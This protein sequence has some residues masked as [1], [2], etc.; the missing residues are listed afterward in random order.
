MERL[1]YIILFIFITGVLSVNILFED[2]YKQTSKEDI[3]ISEYKKKQENNKILTFDEELDSLE[4]DFE[5]IERHYKFVLNHR[6]SEEIFLIKEFYEDKLRTA[7]GYSKD[8]VNYG[9]GL[10]YVHVSS[11]E[12]ALNSFAQVKD[13]DLPHLN[14]SIGF[15]YKEYKLNYD[16]AIHYF[17]KELEVKDAYTDGAYPNLIRCYQILD[18]GYQLQRLALKDEAR[19]HIGEEL[20][21]EYDL[22]NFDLYHYILPHLP[23]PDIVGLIA[24]LIVLFTWLFYLRQLDI[25]KPTSWLGMLV[26]LAV[27]FCFTFLAY[28]MYGYFSYYL[29]FNLDDSSFSN[30]LYYSIFNIG[31]IE[32][33]IKI[34]PFLFILKF[35]NKIQ[36]PIDY[37][38]YASVC[39]LGFSFAENISPAYLSSVDQVGHT[40]GRAFMAA[41]AHMFNTSLIAY[42]LMRSKFKRGE[43]EG[44]INFIKYFTLAMVSHGF[45]DHWLIYVHHHKYANPS[46]GILAYITILFHLSTIL[47]WVSMINNALNNSIFYNRDIKFNTPRL[48]DYLVFSLSFIV[49]F[50][51]V[52]TAYHLGSIDA[53]NFLVK[54]GITVIFLL[55]FLAIHVSNFDI[56][57]R[58]WAP[59]NFHNVNSKTRYNTLVGQ[60]IVF[61]QSREFSKYNNYLPAFGKIISREYFG[62]DT[63]YF[64]VQLD[65][66]ITVK[67]KSYYFII[68]QPL[69]KRSLISKVIPSLT[70][71]SILPELYELGNPNRKVESL[72]T[73]THFNSRIISKTEKITIK[74]KIEEEIEKLNSNKEEIDI[75]S[76]FNPIY[77]ESEINSNEDIENENDFSDLFPSEEDSEDKE[78]DEEKH[79]P[80]N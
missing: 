2:E 29:G 57:H 33:I 80:E 27:A 25:Y 23:S 4:L 60:H 77:R 52:I 53:N 43:A 15:V 61:S 46:V 22:K 78:E 66:A 3:E 6:G 74:K 8:L 47:M 69:R 20:L 55:V 11:H 59:I 9:L 41:I 21:Q 42:G 30:I 39:A 10:Y 12:K 79:P 14:N 1:A 68:I 40:H 63:D 38:I 36:K 16:S 48:R 75:P 62:K 35:T 19:K 58:F 7:K 54:E 49:M 64:L 31:F 13:K 45:Y 56:V 18:S 34:I 24:S 5:N 71:I 72:T 65:K 26:T 70:Q 17:K 44:Y 73:I 32:E 50:E 51:Y 37:I 76:D 28:P 67:G